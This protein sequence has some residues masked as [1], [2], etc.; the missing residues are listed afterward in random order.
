MPLRVG[1]SLYLS[2]TFSRRVVEPCRKAVMSVFTNTKYWY[3]LV[4][5]CDLLYANM[6]LCK[7]CYSG[8]LLWTTCTADATGL[9]ISFHTYSTYLRVP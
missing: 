2:P 5:S 6:I 4:V 8:M 7:I 1:L 3:V 9:I